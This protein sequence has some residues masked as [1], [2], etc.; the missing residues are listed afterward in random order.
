[1]ARHTNLYQRVRYYDIALSR[2]VAHEVDFLVD[3]YRKHCQAPLSSLLEIACGP[4]Y[5]G[6]DAASRGLR[7]VGL[8]LFTEM[9]DFAAQRAAAAGTTLELFAADMREFTLTAPVS[10]AICMFDAI[11]VM[12]TFDDL[13]QHLRT[14]ARNL[15]P[16]GLYLI[17]T[18]HP[19]YSSLSEYG[20][21]SYS[22]ERDGI[23]VQIDWAV[24][25]PVFD[26]VSSVAHVQ[27]EIE[28]DDHGERFTLQDSADER[29]TQPGE[30]QLLAQLSGVFRIA[31]WYGNFDIHQP[32][33]SS[34]NSQ[35]T[36]CILQ[37]T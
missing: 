16:G 15:M 25:N 20:Q 32:L 21:Y 23:S 3:A 31:G 28:V 6:V 1:M 7:V 30:L 2:P 26:P 27:I 35:H 17:H 14:V 36:I 18:T 5:H 12:L 11:D 13:L 34:E 22:G 8:D 24:N 9:T 33:D 4:A 29:L 19:R 37:K 10:M